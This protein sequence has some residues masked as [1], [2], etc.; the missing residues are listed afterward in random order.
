MGR[1]CIAHDR[2]LRY[3]EIDA[4]PG[5]DKKIFH[6]TKCGNQWCVIFIQK[7]VQSSEEENCVTKETLS[8][9]M[10]QPYNCLF[11]CLY[12][13]RSSVESGEARTQ[14]LVDLNITSTRDG[15]AIRTHK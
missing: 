10:S 15:H 13:C 5:F 14:K 3:G 12:N 9:K 11:N 1:T 2:V 8:I 6:A 4:N 7:K